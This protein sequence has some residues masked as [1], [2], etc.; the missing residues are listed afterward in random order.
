VRE[1]VAIVGTGV[2]GMGA[3]WQLRHAADIT[4][5]ERDARPGGHTNT[6]TID[7]EGTPVPIDTGFIV[8]NHATYPN[9]VEL[10]RELGVETKPA[11]MSFSVR[12][13]PADLEYNGMG[14]DKLFAQRRNILRPRFHVLVLT[15][16]R[17]FRIA[18]KALE[19]PASLECT[20]AEFVERHRLGRDFLEFY[21]VPMSSAVWSTEPQ[22]MLDFPALS[23]IRF[24]QNHGFL[25]VTTHHPWFTVSSGSQ[26]YRDKILAAFDPVRLPAKVVAVSEGSGSAKVRLED[27]AELEFDRV[28]IAAHADEA[29]EMLAAPDPDQ[30]RLL[31][32]FRYQENTA[33]LH[34]DS[35]VMPRTR[36][37]WAAWNYRVERQPGGESSATT[38]YW[39]NALQGVSKK[40]DYFV[41]INGAEN[42]RDAA[43]LYRTVYHHPV[44]TLEAMRAQRELP[45]LNT[46]SAQQRLFFCGSYFRHGFH[47]DAYA[48]AVDLARVLR[49]NLGR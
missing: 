4:L 45:S 37:A 19:N 8:F 41:S 28:I 22:R 39:M 29:L 38:H 7:E 24:F 18:R 13:E 43:V 5:I 3:A 42:I 34:T 46:R 35:S 44:F 21:L 1:R 2:A 25:G 14:L 40:R 11:E 16:M 23:L 31:S 6:V 27:G 20:V 12:H 9:L 26:T 32:A 10:F 36:R 48:S 47:E 33:T 15:I 17:F 30:Q 49:P